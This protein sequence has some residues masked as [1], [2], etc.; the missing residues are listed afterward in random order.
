MLAGAAA[1]FFD[2]AFGLLSL[3]LL[4]SEPLEESLE[5]SLDESLDESF[6]AAVAGSEPRLL[7]L[8]SVT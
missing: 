3:V 1:F 7:L 5:E 2:S 8:L 4:L 6:T